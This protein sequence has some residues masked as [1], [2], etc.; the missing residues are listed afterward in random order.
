MRRELY[1]TRRTQRARTA[2]I[3]RL[4]GAERFEFTVAER[5]AGDRATLHKSGI[6]TIGAN[7]T[8]RPDIDAVQERL[9]DAGNGHA[10]LCVLRDSLVA[11]DPLLDDA[12]R[13]CSIV[14]EFDGSVPVKGDEVRAVKDKPMKLNDHALD[15]LRYG[16]MAIDQ[17]VP[18]VESADT[19]AKREHTEWEEKERRWLGPHAERW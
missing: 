6:P 8:V 12:E 2:E 15:A 14:E 10:R 5:D 18:P 19:R 9:N 13:P 1:Q 4:A 7:K 16:T 11:R 3:R 17:K